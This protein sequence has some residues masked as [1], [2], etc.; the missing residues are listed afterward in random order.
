MTI[1]P[2]RSVF[3]S[4]LVVG[5]A[6]APALSAPSA[7][8]GTYQLDPE[9]TQVVFVIKHMGLSNFFG[10]FGKITGT[11]AFDQAAPEQSV[12]NVQIDMHG[13]ETHVPELDTILVNSIFQADKYPNASFV[14][15][16]I[17][18]AGDN[19]GTVNGD[20]TIAGVTKPVTLSVTFNG[21]RG[22]GEPMQPYRIGFDA[23]TAVKR[24]DFGLT[25]MIWTGFVG[26]DVQLLIEAEAVRR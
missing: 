22:S 4:V 1:R 5:L 15:T 18:K 12:L 7:P 19:T 14:S 20:L 21:G 13:I 25:H 6:A 3:L 26:D 11:L 16:A 2:G 24:S 17:K 9:H 23:T 8:K 10:R